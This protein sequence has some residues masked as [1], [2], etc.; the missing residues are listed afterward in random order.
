MLAIVL[1][2]AG[3]GANRM[4]TIKSNLKTLPALCIAL[5]WLSVSQAVAAS[6]LEELLG[7]TGRTV[8]LFWQDVASF[9]CTEL[10]TQEKFGERGKKEYKKESNFDYLALAKTF[11]GA[12][13]VE[14]LRMP[15]KK[16][17]DKVNKPA[18]LATNGFPT[19][20]LM[21]HPKYQSSYRYQIEPA[22]ERDGKLICVR[23]EHIPGTE[24]T[25]ALA[26]QEKIYPLD[27]QGTAWIDNETGVIQKISARLSA[28]MK[29]IN[30]HEFSVEVIYK[31]QS[32][33]PE[34]E[35]KWLPSTVAIDLHTARQHWRNT[36]HFSQYKQ[37]TVQSSQSVSR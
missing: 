17:S 10:V 15:K 12:L 20:V 29:D 19:L 25:C 28:P 35:T 1:T 34:P 7:R 3:E 9:A 8:E 30:I 5:L 13:T 22:S 6:Q 24:S 32:F 37:F 27:M 26:L 11:E 4:P 31:P 16:N 33:H 18:V 23:F 14:E 36:H 2:T 21:F